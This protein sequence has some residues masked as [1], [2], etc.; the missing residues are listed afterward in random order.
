MKQAKIRQWGN[1]LAV[2]IPADLIRELGLREGNTIIL[3]REKKTIVMR[4]P[5]KRVRGGSTIWQKFLIPTR[6]KKRCSVSTTIDTILY[7][8]HR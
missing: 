4:H 1:S 3:D 8:A 2:R 7:G 6:G 5:I